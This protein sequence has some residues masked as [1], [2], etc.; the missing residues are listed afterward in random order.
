M[1]N[2]PVF[3][4][5]SFAGQM[6][7]GTNPVTFCFVVNWMSEHPDSEALTPAFIAVIKG[8]METI[9]QGLPPG[10]SRDRIVDDSESRTA[11]WPQLP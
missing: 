5:L 3:H 4:A 9:K 6:V 10:S 11:T 8:S 7:V 1:G 2:V